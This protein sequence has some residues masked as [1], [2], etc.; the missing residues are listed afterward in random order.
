VKVL[1]GRLEI[2]DG[3]LENLQMELDL[4]V[5][6]DECFCEYSLGLDESGE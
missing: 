3:L 5:V 2:K 6:R 4:E 1:R